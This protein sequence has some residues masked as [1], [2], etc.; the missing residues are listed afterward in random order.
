MNLKEINP[1]PNAKK[2]N[3]FYESR[4]GFTIDFNKMTVPRA[5]RIY[6]QLE[7]NLVKIKQAHGIYFTETN[8]KYTELLS[9]KEGLA[10]W[11][12]QN[13]VLTEDE[14]T[15]AEVKVAAKGMVD[16][17]Q[18]MIEKAGKMQNEDLAAIVSSARNQIGVAQAD[19]FNAAANAALGTM[20]ETLKAQ[21][22]ALDMA[23]RKMSGQ[24][25]GAPDM[26]VAGTE[27]VAPEAGAEA[28]APEA[29]AGEDQFGATA[30]AA[31]GTAP[32]GRERR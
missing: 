26:A 17:L 25:I 4:F 16:E 15:E 19:E 31:G 29:A 30:A 7:E 28:V 13:R 2:L 1:M 20:L 21:K 6:R 8:P 5:R 11:L 12:K 22:D 10:L 32:L 3:R 23:Y 14:A 24:E 18:A 9:V 27:P